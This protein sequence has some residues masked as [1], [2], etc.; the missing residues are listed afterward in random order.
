MPQVITG[1]RVEG[2]NRYQEQIVPTTRASNFRVVGTGITGADVQ[3]I[4]F[5]IVRHAVPDGTTGACLPVLAGP[6]FRRH[7]HHRVARV[8]LGATRRGI[9]T[10]SLLA[11]FDIVGRDIPPVAPVAASMTNNDLV[12]EYTRHTGNESGT[13]LGK[14]SNTP[15]QL[16]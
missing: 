3:L 14:C 7:L 9:E 1:V 2:D 5:L 16:T 13:P 15:Q 6:G 12:L 10:P 4:Q 11:R 8:F